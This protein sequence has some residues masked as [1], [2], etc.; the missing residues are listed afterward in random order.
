VIA[1]VAALNR[2]QGEAVRRHGWSA[3]GGGGS[4]ELPQNGRQASQ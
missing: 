3:L 1:P 2:G 4:D